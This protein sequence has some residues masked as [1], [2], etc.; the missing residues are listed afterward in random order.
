MIGTFKANIPYNNFFLFLYALVIRVPSLLYSAVPHSVDGDGVIYT[1]LLNWLKTGNESIYWYPVISLVLVYIQALSINRIVNRQRLFPK[2]H[3]LTG[4]SY[5]LITA[6]FPDW[7]VLSAAM[8]VNTLMIWVWSK[9]MGL[10]NDMRPKSTLFNL[11]FILSATTFFYNPTFA[12]FILIIMG[13]SIS[14]PFKAAEWVIVCIGLATPFYFYLSWLYLTD[15]WAAFQWPRFGFYLKHF[16]DSNWVYSGL[17]LA[18][19]TTCLGIYFVQSNMRRQVVQTR[20]SWHILYLYLVTA[21]LIPFLT[22]V[23]GFGH[24]ILVA[25]PLSVFISAAFFYPEKKFF[26]QLIHWALFLVALLTGLYNNF[27]F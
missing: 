19:F 26:P 2:S 21:M 3:Y 18:V 7:Y 16:Q 20:K 10:G 9:L 14:R 17:A 25:V 24:R 4:M 5:L 27:N 22:A 1:A 23:T 6:L 12:F 13:L 8:L 11:G 15:R